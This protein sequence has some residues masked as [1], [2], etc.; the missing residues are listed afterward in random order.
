[1]CD[2]VMLEEFCVFD[3]VMFEELCV[4]VCDG[5]MFEELCVCV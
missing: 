2:G 1:M 3:R 5:V 4:C